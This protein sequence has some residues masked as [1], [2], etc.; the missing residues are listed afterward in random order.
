L[1]VIQLT[2]IKRNRMQ[3]TKAAVGAIGVSLAKKKHDPLYKK[4]IF[5]KDKYKQTKDQL[6]K[7][8]KSKSMVLARQK[9]SKFQGD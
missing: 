8:Y 6:Q 5:Y 2:S 3:K 1:K 7:K 4:M 9:A